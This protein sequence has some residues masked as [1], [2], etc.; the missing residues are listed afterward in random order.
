MASAWFVFL[1]RFTIWY[2]HT[3]LCRKVQEGDRQISL[4]GDF[5]MGSGCFSCLKY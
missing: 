3:L 1:S 5:Q 4:R 2:Y